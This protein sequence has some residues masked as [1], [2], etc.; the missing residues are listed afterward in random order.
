M[1][2]SNELGVVRGL[3]ELGILYKEH[4][5]LIVTTLL[6]MIIGAILGAVAF[7]NGWLG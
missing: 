4:P 2:S 3:K 6:G 1:K 5:I 7:Y